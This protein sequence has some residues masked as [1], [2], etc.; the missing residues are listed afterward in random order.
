MK[1]RGT[2]RKRKKWRVRIRGRV[3]M[4]V[5]KVGKL[6]VRGRMRMEVRIR[7]R[8][9]RRVLRF[10]RKVA[11]ESPVSFR[12]WVQMVM[13]CVHSKTREVQTEA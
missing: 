9:A 12:C 8:V 11:N 2:R 3:R 10:W 7:M 13:R 4:E 6:R 5:M 1:R